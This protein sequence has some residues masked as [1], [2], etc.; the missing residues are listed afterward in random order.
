VISSET[1]GQE[2]GADLSLLEVILELIELFHDLRL[3]VARIASVGEKDDGDILDI[4]LLLHELIDLLEHSH[5][6]RASTGLEGGNLLLIVL[7]VWALNSEHLLIVK[8]CL[9]V[10]EPTG[11]EDG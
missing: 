11:L 7:K 6:V 9:K 3:R 1:D 5:K 10:L 4:I 2:A 8:V